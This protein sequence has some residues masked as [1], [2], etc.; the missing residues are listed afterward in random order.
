MLKIFLVEDEMVVREGIKNKIDWAEHGFEFAG[1]ASDGELAYPLIQ[2]LR[3]DVLIT[4]IKMPFM[5]GLELARLVRQEIPRMKIIILSGYDEF[6][7]AKEAIAIGVTEYLL[8][9]VASAKIVE[10]IQR[11]KKIID[12][13]HLQETYL[14]RYRQE[15]QEQAGLENKLFFEELVSGKQSVSEL[16]KKAKTLGFE[17]IAQNY[18]IILFKFCME[19]GVSDFYSEKLVRL[20]KKL[21]EYLDEQPSALLFERGLEGYAL[22]VKG[23]A[24]LSAETAARTYAEKISKIFQEEPGIFYFVGI[25]EP[26]CRLLEIPKAFETASR[27]FA[28]HY[29]FENSQVVHYSE[30]QK[31]SAAQDADISL[32]TLDTSKID[33]MIVER[34]LKSGSREN[35]DHFVEDYFESLGIVHIQSFLFRQYIIMDI[36]LAAAAFLE[37]LGHGQSTLIE[38]CGDLDRVV[39]MAS[40]VQEAKN[41]V[42]T[43]LSETL[44]VRDLFSRKKYDGLI[45]RAQEYIR[46]NYSREDIS[47]NHVAQAVNISPTHFSAIFSQETGKTFIEYLT[48]VRM[49]KAKE[50]LRCSGMKSSE[51]SY[52]VG[53][54]DPHYF[55][56][57]F[58]KMQGRTPSEFRTGRQKCV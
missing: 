16:L 14:Q 51:I 4:D 28:Y 22:L 27:A 58:K 10:T 3:P 24:E 44:A 49:E 37:E 34:F 56:Y 29:I 48:G 45:Q 39:G 55:S 36:R 21:E 38:R 32:K 12:E 40:T 47:L 35:T 6:Q 30:I 53:Y 43:V 26:V 23:G 15:M 54:K 7:Y 52:A 8:K 50:L 25:G 42:K 31:L 33:K 9:P 19:T 18:Q 11:V 17:L 1:E 5:D 13:E 20:Q 57:L 2:K 41:Y 46:N